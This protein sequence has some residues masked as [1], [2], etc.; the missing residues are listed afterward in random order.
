[1]GEHPHASVQQEAASLVVVCGL[2]G[3]GKSTVARRVADLI[4]AEVLRTDV[5]RKE[6]FDDPEYTGEE[7]ATVYDELLSRA[8]DR[9]VDGDRVVLDATFRT[10]EQRE[11][12]RDLAD[13]LDCGFRVVH[14]DCEEA[15][16]ER[17]IAEREGVSDADFAVHQQLRETFEPLEVAHVAVD[18][19]GSEAETRRQV[20]E[21]FRL[22][23]RSR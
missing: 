4:D 10:R 17:R 15:V 3:V 21:A 14:V 2:P 19:S 11:A 1:M 23:R 12:A 13:R 5:V 20:D 18:N 6:L 9:L 16:V 22:N 8:E 7:T